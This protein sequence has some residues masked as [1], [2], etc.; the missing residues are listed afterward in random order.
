MKIKGLRRKISCVVIFPLIIGLILTRLAAF[1]PLYLYYPT[2]L[3]SYSNKMIETQTTTLLEIS[4]LLSSCTSVNY[5]QKIV[6]A[7]NIAGDVMGSYLFYN[8]AVKSSFNSSL[9]YSSAVLF[10]VDNPDSSVQYDNLSLWYINSNITVPSQLPLVSQTNLETSGIFNTVIKPVSELG[11]F[12]GSTYSLSYLVFTADGLMYTHPAT[13]FAYVSESP[14]GVCSYNEV[15][16][17]HYD[18]RCR[19]FYTTTLAAKTNDVVFTTPYVY[20]DGHTR[21]ETACRAQW[22]YTTSSMLLIYCVDFLVDLNLENAAVNLTS[23]MIYS[24]ILDPVGGVMYH[25]DLQTSNDS[26]ASITQLEFPEDPHG[27]EAAEFNATILPLFLNQRTKIASYKRNGEEMN[28]AV[29]PVL[30]QMG[31]GSTPTHI[32]SVGVVMKKSTLESSFNSLEDTCNNMLYIELY[33]SI[34]LL[35]LIGGFCI[36]LT[37]KI[38]SSVVAPI[39]HLLGIL[40]RMKKDDL[41]M[42]ILASYEPSPP[43]IACLYEVFDKLRVVLR[44][45]KI[46]HEDPTVTSLIYSQALHLFTNFG[47]LTAMEICY[48]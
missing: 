37:Y 33:A 27:K 26:L 19:P 30:M 6:N 47:N 17:T 34:A 11:I 40:D 3:N 28:I 12:I 20:S 7:L 18:P 42:D 14:S 43:E 22:N 2:L 13:Y 45:K 8:L 38:T 44:F 31:Y 1:L 39:D 5:M 25:P 9:V 23:N 16:P 21:G 35:V 24:Y 41:S 46:P 36:Y 29:T 48:R 32:A 15:D 10:N 4:T